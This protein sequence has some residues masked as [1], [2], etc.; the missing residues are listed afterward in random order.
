MAE[1]LAAGTVLGVASSILNFADVGLRIMKRLNEYYGERKD[2]PKVIRHIRVQLR[3]LRD[4]MVTLKE[5]R[6]D[7]SLI[8]RPQS[9]LGETIRCC[10]QQIVRVDVLITKMFPE[11]S[12]S[13]A[14]R[15]K[16]AL[17]SILYE[18]ELSKVWAELD[19]YKLTLVFHFTK[20]TTT[21]QD[22][23]DIAL[24]ARQ[25]ILSWLSPLSFEDRQAELSAKRIPNTGKWFLETTQF[26][27][28]L[29]GSRG[30]T[31]WCYGT[32]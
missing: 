32:R 2:I 21:V 31:L 3:V 11:K 23:P 7:G 26:Q 19:D 24:P 9:A 16:K 18:K 22:R 12:D 1:L 5:K 4:K 17:S 28:W 27:S 15:A 30:S 10:E 13:K 20:M 14:V 25:T 6:D 8:I 29:Q